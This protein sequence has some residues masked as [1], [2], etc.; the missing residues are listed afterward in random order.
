MQLHTTNSLNEVVPSKESSPSRI[1]NP[2]NYDP[3][4]ILVS[5]ALSFGLRYFSLRQRRVIINM[6][7]TKALRESESGKF[8]QLDRVVLTLLWESV[9][10][11]RNLEW[12]Q[13]YADWWLAISDYT[14]LTIRDQLLT[15][16]SQR[17]RDQ[18]YNILRENG[19]LP[20]LF[21]YFG[22]AHVFKT[23]SCLSRKNRN[24]DRK[25]PPKSYI[26]VG[27]KDSGN[28]KDTAYDGSPHWVEVAS[29]NYANYF[30][31]DSLS[32]DL[33]FLSF[34]CGNCFGNVIS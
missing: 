7:L 3:T 22:W 17:F 10:S 33:W 28:K 19:H 12:S 31:K 18:V 20:N 4:K 6:L 2:G 1:P 30:P 23:E 25:P 34:R 14:E 15:H 13:R 27:Y 9:S 26:G 21:E 8:T 29:S 32:P 24:L 11:V 5:K 16:T